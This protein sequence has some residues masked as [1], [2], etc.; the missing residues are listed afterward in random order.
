MLASLFRSGL[1]RATETQS[2]KALTHMVKAYKN[3][4]KPVPLFYKG[5]SGLRASVLPNT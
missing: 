1:Y 3:H 4:R 2:F 5:K